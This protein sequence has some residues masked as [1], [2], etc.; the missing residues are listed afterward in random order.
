MRKLKLW[1]VASASVLL[2]NLS[3]CASS[4]TTSSVAEP[5]YTEKVTLSF[6][7]SQDWVQDAE[8][9]LARQFDEKTGI[10]VNYQI[11]PSS[12]YNNLLMTKLNTGE[13]PD[14]FAAQSGKF[15]IKSQYCVEKNAIDLSNTKWASRTEPLAAAEL[16]VDGRLYGQP[17][18][19]V[20][21]VW[22]LGYNK[23]IFEELN[24]SSSSK[25]FG[26]FTGLFGYSSFWNYPNL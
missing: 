22:A 14:I 12:Q 20:S 6:M 9:D 7:A 3:S 25:L 13:C 15:D 16:S 4:S 10:G 23:K 19:D 18:Q 8:L 1:I 2:L 21:A 24:F 26:I 17:T 5:V 11:F